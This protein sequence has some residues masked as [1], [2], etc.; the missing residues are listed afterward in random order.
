M[1]ESTSTHVVFKEI[2]GFPGY[3]IGDDGSV[4]TLKRKGGN[5]RS[6]GQV[7]SAW[8]R[9]RVHKTKGYCRVNFIRDGRNHSRGIH[10]L[11]L[12]AFVGPCPEGMEACHY[13][14][15]DKSNNQIGNLRWDTHDANMKDR[16]RDRAP[17][18]EK[19]CPRCQTVKSRK[20]FYGD[21]RASDG[22]KT[23]CKTCHS[24]ASYQ[25]RRRRNEKA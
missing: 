17:V 15:P 18:V 7:G 21:K 23:E 13:P 14:D 1:S 12:E 19:Q 5:N 25:A 3:L 11:M 16:Y 8:K 10:Q 6:A 4:W 20:D 24:K 22:L 2:A 9:M